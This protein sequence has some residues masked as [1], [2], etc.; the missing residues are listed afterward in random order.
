MDIENQVDE[1]FY[2]NTDA[3]H[4]I[5]YLCVCV[6]MNKLYLKEKLKKKLF[7]CV[8]HSRVEGFS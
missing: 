4:L 6:C 2:G 5:V 3:L 8:N 7:G 1:I